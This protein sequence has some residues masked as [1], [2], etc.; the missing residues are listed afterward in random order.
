MAVTEQVSRIL[1][2][3]TENHKYLKEDQL[4]RL[5]DRILSAGHIFVAGAGRSGTVARAFAN[6]LMHLGF[7]V[8]F[9]GEITS[10]HSHPGDLVLILSGS[11]ET[12]SL[13][14]LAEKARKSGV[15]VALITMNPGSSIAELA[16][17]TAV[18]PGVSPKIDHQ[19]TTIR[20]VQPMG[21]A[22]EQ[23]TQLV[24]DGLVLELME[25][26]G[27]NQEEMFRRH[28]DFE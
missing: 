8:S 7:H 24:C 10:P 28:A 21:S 1:S 3:L 20:S 26:T 9:V 2:E 11:G 25:R 4:Q 22:F 17:D 6:R 19:K 27:Q 12:A 13:V 23:M 18:L 14:A 16:D 15:N 5:S